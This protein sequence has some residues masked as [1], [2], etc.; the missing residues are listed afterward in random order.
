MSISYERDKWY[1][2]SEE[3]E[4]QHLGSIY[5]VTKDGQYLAGTYISYSQFLSLDEKVYEDHMIEK[6]KIRD[7]NSKSNHPSTFVY[8]DCTVSLS[9]GKKVGFHW[10]ASFQVGNEEIYVNKESEKEAIQAIKNKI[11]SLL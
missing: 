3:P 5:F 10:K 4:P 1:M 6:W 2:A 7:R 11:D 9:T 8:K